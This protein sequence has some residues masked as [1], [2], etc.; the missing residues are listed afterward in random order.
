MFYK[1]DSDL[2][3]TKKP[4]FS[5][6]SNAWKWRIGVSTKGRWESGDGEMVKTFV[7]VG[8]YGG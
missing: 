5:T 8:D 3:D 2:N 6:S 1:L 7:L 4:T